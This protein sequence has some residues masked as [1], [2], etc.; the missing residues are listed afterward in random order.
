M[1]VE[2]QRAAGV[3]DVRHVAASAG[4][5]PD[6][7]RV[8]GAEGDLARLRPLAQAGDGVEQVLHL[9]AREVRV[10]HEAGAVAEEVLQAVRA[11]GVADRRGHAALPD[12]RVADRPARGALPEDHGL[13][14]VGDADGGDVGGRHPRGREAR[15]RD[16]ELRGP[17]R[18]RVVLDV[19]RLRE[20]LRV[21]LL[22]HRHRASVA[23]EEDRA[24]G[25]RPLVE[26][27]NVFHARIVARSSARV[28]GSGSRTAHRRQRGAR[29]RATSAGPGRARRARRAGRAG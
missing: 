20:E 6:E 17:D 15:A 24:R 18:L 25:R 28:S 16:R 5:P 21:L 1:D 10:E 29:R 2:H 22:R 9:G 23:A 4:E 26:R 11:Q 3:A 19:A 7:E 27:Q 14:L 8:D 13:P 12:D